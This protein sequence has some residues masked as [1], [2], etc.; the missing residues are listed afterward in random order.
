MPADVTIGHT[1]ARFRYSMEKGVGPAGHTIAGE[2]EDYAVLV[3]ADEPVANPDSFEVLENSIRVPL[4]VLANDFPSAT[5]VPFIVS[6]TQP[7]RWHRGDCG[8]QA[9]PVLH[10]E[11]RYVSPPLDEFTYT[12]GDGTGQA[13]RPPRESRCW[14]CRRS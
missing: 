14:S 3:L 11:P 10:A 13:S 8:R 1:F 7:P 9:E 6:V 4:D 5:R 12:I 2:V